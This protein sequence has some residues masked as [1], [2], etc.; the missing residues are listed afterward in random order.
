MSIYISPN[1]EYP[2]HDGDVI[3]ANPEWQ[4]GQ[5]LPEGW[6]SVIPTNSPEPQ[7]GLVIFE[8]EP[9]EIDGV[10][11]QSW[12]TR[13][14]T[15]DEMKAKELLAVKRKVMMNLPL[16]EAEALLLVG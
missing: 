16:T 3:I 1:N 14:I 5:E 10:Y 12:D 6:I 2:R 7:D 15:A 13:P 9:V 4:P 8:T 11:Y